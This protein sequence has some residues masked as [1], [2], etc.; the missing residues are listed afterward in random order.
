MQNTKHFQS[1]LYYVHPAR[2]N[3]KTGTT[4][5]AARITTGRGMEGPENGTYWKNGNGGN[6]I[7]GMERGGMDTMTLS[8]LPTHD[9]HTHRVGQKHH[10]SHDDYWKLLPSLMVKVV[11]KSVSVWRHITSKITMA[12]F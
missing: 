2:G 4:G 7:G 8:E 1:G 6:P 12:L 9:E 5:V 11:R 10:I 3:T